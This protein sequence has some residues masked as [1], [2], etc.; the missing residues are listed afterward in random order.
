MAARRGRSGNRKRIDTQQ[1]NGRKGTRCKGSLSCLSLFCLPLICT[2]LKN[3]LNES[4][5][6][7]TP[8]IKFKGL[9][10][11]AEPVNGTLKSFTRYF[12]CVED[13]RRLKYAAG[14]GMAR[15][16]FHMKPLGAFQSPK[17]QNPLVYESAFFN[18]FREDMSRCLSVAFRLFPSPFPL[19]QRPYRPC[20]FAERRCHSGIFRFLL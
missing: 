18:L 8:R 13:F 7:I 1:E 12:I 4:G 16:S 3:Q 6:G 20:R 14:K 15:Q 10:Y 2:E 9:F 5:K 11:R 19:L 17:S